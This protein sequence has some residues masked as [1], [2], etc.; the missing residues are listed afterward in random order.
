M[1]SGYGGEHDSIV[2]ECVKQGYI[3]CGGNLNNITV[4]RSANSYLNQGFIDSLRNTGFNF[5]VRSTTGYGGFTIQSLAIN[6]PDILFIMP[7]GSNSHINTGNTLSII[8][9]TGAGDTANKTGYPIHFYDK[10]TTGQMASSY[11]NGYIA[12]KLAR[13]KDSSKCSLSDAF[14]YAK[15]STKQPFSPTNGYG[16]IDFSNAIYML[17]ERKYKCKQILINH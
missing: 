3:D 10:D 12:G 13:I 8:V 6:N 1:V 7:S 9:A 2:E 14:N 5:L 11:S 4:I 15:L 17:N 16:K